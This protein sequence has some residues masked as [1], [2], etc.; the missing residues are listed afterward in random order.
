MFVDTR[1]HRDAGHQTEIVKRLAA[2]A[3]Q[4]NKTPR[5]SNNMVL[6]G[7]S[8]RINSPYKKAHSVQDQSTYN[9]YTA[10]QAV[11]Q[12]AMPVNAKMPQISQVCYSSNVMPDFN[13]KLRIY[14]QQATIQASV[15]N[16]GRGFSGANCCV[17][18]GK[19]AQYTTA[20]PCSLTTAQQVAFKDV[21]RRF[22]TPS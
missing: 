8:T 18:C 3:V 15:N 22:T 10:G 14:P 6:D 5:T 12:G 9:D 11:A 16:Y 4:E 19:P 17:V 21:K 13:D 7:P 1:P 2:S 20:C